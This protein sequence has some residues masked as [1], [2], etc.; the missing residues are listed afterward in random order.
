MQYSDMSKRPFSR[1]S[2]T[3]GSLLA[4]FDHFVMPEPNSGC[5]LW[6]GPYFKHRSGYGC[7]T[8]RPMGIIQ[9]RAHRLSWEIHCGEVPKGQHVLHKCDNT[10][11]VN[12]AHLFLGGHLANMA[13][14]DAK[15]R[16]NR[17][18][19]HGMVKLTQDAVCRIFSDARLQKDIAQE[20]GVSVVTVSDIKRGRSWKHLKLLG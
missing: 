18:E 15:S 10:S 1:S 19:T 5:W 3:G 2:T 4:A 9:K 16:Q 12:P 8:M 13:D 6:V 11:C 7:F 17:G 20:Y 14:R